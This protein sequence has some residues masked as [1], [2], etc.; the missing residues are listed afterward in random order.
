MAG[1]V[2]EDGL[3]I[4]PGPEVYLPFYQH[5]YAIRFLSLVVRTTL[6]QATLEP[7]MKH[8]I[9]SLNSDS[10]VTMREYTEMMQ[11]TVRA[12]RFRSFLISSFALL[13]LLLAMVGIYGL[14][15][16]SVN[17]RKHEI[18]IRL[19]LGAQ[20]VDVLRFMLLQGLLLV[21]IGLMLG[22]ALAFTMSR[23]MN[24]F[25]YGISPND[26]TIFGA[27]ALLLGATAMLASYFPARHAAKI[28]PMVILRY[29]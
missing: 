24:R 10:P 27:A 28:D 26:L 19:A 12:P 20:R 21:V 29:E 18:G 15:S 2:R 9:R 17:Q 1:D 22:L 6:S 14:V 4:T 13:A 25:L 16:Q 3:G 8:E 7:S 5:P 23:L 11:Q